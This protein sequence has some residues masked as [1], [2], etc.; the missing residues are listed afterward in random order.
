MTN[1]KGYEVG[2]TI[3]YTPFGGGVRRVRVVESFADVKNGEPGFD[4]IV[5]DGPEEGATVWGYDRQ[6]CIDGE[7]GL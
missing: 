5:L 2:D 6:V 7:A 4:G 3:S 1:T